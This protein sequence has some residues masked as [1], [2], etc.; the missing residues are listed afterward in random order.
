[1][2]VLYIHNRPSGGAGES[3]FQMINQNDLWISA[4]VVFVSDGFLKEKFKRLEPTTKIIFQTGSSW[5]GAWRNSP[6]L[7]PFTQLYDFR[8]KV[9]FF[10]KI[11]TL[12]KD[13]KVDVIHTN[14]INLIE[15]GIVG[16]LLGIPHFLQ[17][18]E[19]MDL[20]YYQLP[21]KNAWALKIA[22]K[23]STR[24]IANSKRTLASIVHHGVHEKNIEVI[25]NLV[26]PPSQKL[27]IRT[28]LNLSSD[29]QIVAIVG[30]IT[31]NKMVEDF[32]EIAKNFQTDSKVKFVIIGGWG[33]NQAYNKKIEQQMVGVSNLVHAGLVKNA[34]D[35]MNSFD[36]LLCPC[37]TESFGRTVAEALIVETPAIGV[38]SCAVA[39]IIDHGQ[40]G[41]L[42]EKSD[43]K[44]FSKYVRLLL[45][46]P[47]K[48][49][50][51]GNFGK[52]QMEIR[53]GQKKI[54]QDFLNLYETHKN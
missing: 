17:V 51:M 22:S 23:F 43:I 7:Y 16:Q 45:S 28:L 35:Y 5:L 29:T 14:T 52:K 33:G 24:L 38:K 30:W 20:D 11:Y 18:R 32:I 41:Y 50:E 4:A 37:F 54:R 42:V 2:K 40:S 1:M 21:L 36:I 19:L 12:A 53:F 15:G 27:E 31:P 48:R 13:L 8:R 34:V 39:E 47:E 6:W 25:Y 46:E 3:L 44:A 10:L 26:N 49:K 9:K